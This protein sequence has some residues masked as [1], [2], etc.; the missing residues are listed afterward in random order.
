MAG[1]ALVGALAIG[2]GLLLVHVIYAIDRQREPW[3][4]VACYV[5]L[6]VMAVV[7]AIVIELLERPLFGVMAKTPTTDGLVRILVLS[8]LGIALVEESVK[9]LALHLRARRDGHINEGIDWIVY[10]VA[11]AIGFALIEN[12]FYVIKGGLGVAVARA[13]T[14]VPAHALNGTLMGDRLARAQ[15]G[16]AGSARREKWLAILEPTFWHGIYDFF[17]LGMDHELRARQRPRLAIA[18]GIGLVASIFLQWMIVVARIRCWRRVGAP[19]P[20]PAFPIE[21]VRRFTTRR[22]RS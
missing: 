4:N 2:P 13:L 10:S 6:G 1:A 17:A 9:R 15:F 14:A 19:V 12:V 22:S 11:V 8:F 5:L 7:P 20:P 18:L 3:R 16:S 21:V